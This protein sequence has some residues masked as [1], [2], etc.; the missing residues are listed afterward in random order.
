MMRDYRVYEALSEAGCSPAETYLIARK[1]GMT[2]ETAIHMLTCVFHM[3]LVEARKIAS[4]ASGAAALSSMHNKPL[5]ETIT[6]EV[7]MS[8]RAEKFHHRAVCLMENYLSESV[9]L[10]IFERQFGELWQD[11]QNDMEL[12]Y[13]EIFQRES[14]RLGDVATAL[15]LLENGSKRSVCRDQLLEVVYAAWHVLSRSLND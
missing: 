4:L 14:Q 12:G 2:V 1:D 13:Y 3:T 11:V 15:R 9:P 10:E 8:D 7:S 6:A 5:V